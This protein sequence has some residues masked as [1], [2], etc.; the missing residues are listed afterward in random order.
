MIVFK[1]LVQNTIN[2]LLINILNFEY[3]LFFDVPPKEQTF[4]KTLLT[5]S[6]SKMSAIIAVGFVNNF[7][8]SVLAYSFL[9]CA[10]L[11]FLHSFVPILTRKCYTVCNSSKFSKP[12][13]LSTNKAF[14][15]TCNIEKWTEICVYDKTTM[16]QHTTSFVHL[17]TSRLVW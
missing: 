13:T 5:I 11:F 12:K 2:N 14:C 16:T 15:L 1:K 4:G 6:C 17:Y 10:K 9:V 3:C 8:S 7:Y